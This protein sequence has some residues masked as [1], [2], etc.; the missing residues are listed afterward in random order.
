MGKDVEGNGSGIFSVT[1][2]WFARSAWR[3][4]LSII[5][6]IIIIIIIYSFNRSIIGN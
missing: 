2:Q 3:R 1:V 6:I 5:I 4:I